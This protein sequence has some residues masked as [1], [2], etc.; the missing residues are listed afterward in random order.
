MISII[1][2]TYRL[3]FF[4]AL[5]QNIQ[6]TIGNISYEIIQVWNPGMMSLSE[7]YN[8]GAK[9]AQ[10]D[11]LL[12]LH[13][14]VE[15]LVPNWGYIILKYSKIE[16]AGVCGLAGSLKKFHLPTGFETGIR[17]YRQIYV[18]HGREDE[19]KPHSNINFIK[20]KTLDGVFLA[21]SKKVWEILKFNEDIK[22]YHF[23]DLDISLRSSKL[24]QNYVIDDLPLF[25][26]SLGCFNDSWLKASL[27]F[28]SGGY[29]FDIATKEEL[30][31]TRIF[32]YS[33]LKYEDISLKNR[34]RYIVAM[35]FNWQ[36]KR[37]AL[38][39]LFPGLKKTIKAILHVN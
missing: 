25:H 13:E 29:D 24:F 38:K 7:A 17:K 31:H 1:V 21:M 22:G 26:F 32:W 33:R 3:E 11:F 35:G 6:L 12:F 34:M 9:E 16:N 30:D 27:R 18:K 36:S 37:A 28:N 4:N 2:S 15:F 5:S 8:K 19:D 10:Y 39:F 14:D 20:V 23:Y